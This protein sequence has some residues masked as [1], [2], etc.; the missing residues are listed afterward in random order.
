MRSV[1]NLVGSGVAW[2]CGSSWLVA[3]GGN[4][5]QNKASLSRVA[6]DRDVPSQCLLLNSSFLL[7]LFRLLCILFSFVSSEGQWTPLCGRF[8]FISLFP[9]LSSVL[10]VPLTSLEPDV[11]EIRE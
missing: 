9:V 10:V 4:S 6:G 11:R 3:D 1:R 5:N 2:T 7:L 8:L